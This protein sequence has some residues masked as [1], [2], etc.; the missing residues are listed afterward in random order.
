MI[1]YIENNKLD[2]Y[3]LPRINASLE[4]YKLIKTNTH[5]QFLQAI[6]N[7]DK[8]NSFFVILLKANQNISKIIKIQKFIKKVLYNH[9]LKLYGPA[10]NNRSSCINDTDF[11]T[12]DELKDIPNEEFF[13]FTDEKNFVY[14][15]HIDSIT[16]LLFKSDEHYF[17]QFKKKIKNKKIIIN[18]N[19]INLCYKQFINLLSNHYNKIK[20]S[21]PYTRFFLDNKTK[22]NIITLYAKKEYDTNLKNN[23]NNTNIV[24][25]IYY[26]LI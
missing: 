23:N 22:L 26:L 2:T 4:H 5:S 16:Q 25:M 13:S 10:L 12:L 1:D 11:F 15:F 14:G 17:E 8:L 6:N 3:P 7:I 24:I 19:S 21:N 18:N 9:K 20:V